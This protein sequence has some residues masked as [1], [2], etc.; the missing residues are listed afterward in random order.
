MD[1]VG[2]EDHDQRPVVDD[3]LWP[4]PKTHGRVM[5]CDHAAIGKL[6]QLEGGLARQPLEDMTAEI[7]HTLISPFRERPHRARLLCDHGF[8]RLRH[9]IDALLH[10][11]DAAK[12]GQRGVRHATEA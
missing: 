2:Q 6:E 8:N 10:A 9:A 4:V 3:G 7:D 1:M 11:V 12:R 5:S